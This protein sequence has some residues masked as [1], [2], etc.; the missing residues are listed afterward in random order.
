MIYIVPSIKE[1]YSKQFEISVDIKLVKMLT[2]F[3][4]SNAIILSGFK[5]LPKKRKVEK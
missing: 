4:R 3:Y 2:R 5:K 1:P